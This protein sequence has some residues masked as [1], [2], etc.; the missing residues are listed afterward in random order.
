MFVLSNSATFLN[1]NPTIC[2]GDTVYVG[3]NAYYQTGVY[4]NVLTNSVGCDSVISLDLRVVSPTNLVYD[5]CP[6]DSIQVGSNIYYSAGLYVD[7]LV[8]A[9]GCDSV[10]NT[11]INTYSQYNSIYG[12]ILDN[13]V[14][15][16]G[17]Y[18]GD[19]HLILDCYVPTEIVS[20]TVYSD[21]N[22]IYEFELRDNN[23]NTLADTIYALVDGAN[24]VTL[25]FE[26][27]AG[28]DFEL[29]VSPASNFGG[30][31][32]NNA[33]VSFPYDFGNLASIT[34]SSAQQFGDYYYFYYNIEMRA[35]SA[36]AEY[37]I[38]QGES[39]SIGS[40][41]YTT[42]GLYIDTMMSSTGCDSLVYTNL[43][44][45]PIVTYHSKPF[46]KLHLTQQTNV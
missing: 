27:P 26:M 25:N 11:Q 34:Q 24:L 13:T 43:T 41:V 7:S 3:G 46:C 40:N 32:R 23:G 45:N 38:C 22:T 35:S 2:Y 39:I 16:G 10:I 33:G 31:Y 20:A 19:Q 15:G 1:L 29:G 5:I 9:N 8:A 4:T 28:T 6:G 42:S 17:Y 37:S 21:G 12:G 14:G 36:P 30:L 18:T 44:V